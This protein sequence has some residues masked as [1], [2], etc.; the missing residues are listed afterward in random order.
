[1]DVEPSRSYADVHAARQAAPLGSRR[2]QRRGASGV[3]PAAWRGAANLGSL[4]RGGKFALLLGVLADC[5]SD[6]P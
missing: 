5:C 4:G 1:M 3:A 2:R 6:N